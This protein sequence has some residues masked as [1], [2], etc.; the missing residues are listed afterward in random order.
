MSF[1]INEAPNMVL[2]AISNEKLKRGCGTFWSILFCV[3][4]F[5]ATLGCCDN[6]SNT[7]YAGCCWPKDVSIQTDGS[8]TTLIHTLKTQIKINNPSSE[9]STDHANEFDRVEWQVKQTL[10]I[11]DT[12]I[13]K[14]LVDGSYLQALQV[15]RE[16]IFSRAKAEAR[17]KNTMS[18]TT[19]LTGH[20]ISIHDYGLPLSSRKS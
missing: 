15:V 16:E 2:S 7:P 4:T 10:K 8:L 9:K 1:K 12:T 3:P 17:F 11:L 19:P 6:H 13:D 14:N 20:D 5:G 18:E